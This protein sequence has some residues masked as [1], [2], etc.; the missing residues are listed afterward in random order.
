MKTGKQTKPQSNL[1]PLNE[2]RLKVLIN[3]KLSVR[4]IAERFGVT[5][6]VIRHRM[7][8]FKAEKQEELLAAVA[9]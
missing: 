7:I 9:K 6:H 5:I 4:E 1:T 2:N 3:Q 8:R